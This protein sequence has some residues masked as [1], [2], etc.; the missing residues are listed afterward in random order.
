MI[1]IAAA[2]LLAALLAVTGLAPARAQTTTPAPGAS[3]TSPGSTSTKSHRRHTSTTPAATGTTSG[4]GQFSTETEARHSCPSDT[5]VWANAS[6]KT[7]HPSGDR[8]YGK[9]RRG[10]YMCEK[11]AIQDG[12]HLAGHGAVRAKKTATSK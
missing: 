4:R 3:P 6:S 7:L 11:Q 2:S 8:Y 9:T 1:H 10:A 5:V 12:Y